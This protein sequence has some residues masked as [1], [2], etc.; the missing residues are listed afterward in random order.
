MEYITTVRAHEPIA[1]TIGNFDGIHRGHQRLLHELCALAGELDCKPVILT[2]APH[3]LT[4]VRPDLP[5]R[6][7]TTLEEKLALARRYGGVADAIVVRFTPEVAALTARQFL[8]E[9]RSAFLLKALVVG[10]NFSMGHNRE[11]DV[12]FLERYGQEHGLLV[13]AF[14]L[15]ELQGGRVSST[16]IRALVEEGRIAEATGLLGHPPL[17]SGVVVHGDHRGRLLGFPTANLVPE[18]YRLLPAN[19]IYAARV[20]V[21]EEGERD[22]FS[23]ARVYKSAVNVGVRPNFPSKH[24]L[25]EAYLLDV[26]LDLYDRRILVEFIARLREERRFE[27][28][29]ALKAQ[30]AADVEQVRQ[31]FRMGSVSQGEN[32]PE[33]TLE[34]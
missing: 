10:Q 20:T 5:L 22:V 11:G 13:R 18:P 8:D 16:R 14:P 30:M 32:T 19:G 26:E 1:I 2:F 7:L 27:T 6:C 28:I 21:E 25:V 33:S 24:R 9:L 15:E 23:S 12:A 17:I 3:T 31:I 4:V 34:I 29:E